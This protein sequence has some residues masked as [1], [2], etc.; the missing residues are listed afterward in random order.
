M[1][2][3]KQHFNLAEA[4]RR[5]A[6][7]VMVGTV[8]STRGDGYA[9]VKIGELTTGWLPW[10]SP[11]MGSRK[12]WAAPEP[13]EQ[14]LVVCHNGDPAQGLIVASLGSA[15]NP[16]PSENP[17]IFKTVFSDGTFMQ[18]DLDT[19]EMSVGCAGA[20]SVAADGDVSVATAG[21]A[22]LEAVGNIE[23]DSQASVKAT[24]AATAEVTAPSL[25]LTGAVTIAG[26]LN[27][28]GATTLQAA[29]VAGTALVPGGNQF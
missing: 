21:K 25:K 24:A 28:T 22:Q 14:V 11:R 13:A 9:R 15:D 1:V 7:L 18:V 23:V 8:T 26:D 27:V 20:V 19:H 2:D 29:A 10:L 3:H 4:E 16:N 5:I 12:D 17:R 6:N